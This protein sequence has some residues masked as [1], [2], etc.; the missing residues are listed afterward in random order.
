MRLLVEAAA[1]VPE[2]MAEPR[3]LAMFKGFS[4]KSLDFR[5]LAW[6]KTID[7]GLQA[8]NALR[9]A[10]LRKLESAGIAMPPP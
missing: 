8:Q 7:L 2:I 3:P 6:V 4:A 1:D 10:V 9:M 5:L